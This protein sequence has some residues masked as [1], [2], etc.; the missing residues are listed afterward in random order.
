MTR[1]VIDSS[2][3]LADIAGEPG[4]EIVRTEGKKAMIS[5]VNFA[6]II[7]KLIEFGASP[8]E[9]RFV[10]ERGG[11][12]IMPADQQ[13]AAMAGMLHGKT[14]GTGVSLGDRF[15]LALAQETGH[16]VLTADRRWATLDLGVEVVLI[17]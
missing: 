16:P 11:F 5:A 6:E 9:A 4:A 13:R 12:E 7:T 17:R 1:Y 14:R 3:V 8:E 15:C 2:A 10:A